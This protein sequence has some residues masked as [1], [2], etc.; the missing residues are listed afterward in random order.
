MITVRPETIPDYLP[1]SMLNQVEYCP[2][3]FWYMFLQGEMKV[4]APVLDGQLRHERVHSR[5]VTALEDGLQTRRLYV[6]SER[7]RLVGYVDLL[8]SQGGQ[9]Y[10]VEYKRGRAGVW[11]ND[12]VQLCAQALCLEERLGRPIDKGY[13][14]Y[15]G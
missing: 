5:Q 12:R 6:F 8:E 13:I 2:R 4:N 7:L 14:Y 11:L 9:V 15:M 10:P 3:R 1:I